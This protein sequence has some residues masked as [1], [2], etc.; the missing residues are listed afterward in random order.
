MGPEPT[1]S[2]AEQNLGIITDTFSGHLREFTE[3]F[4]RRLILTHIQNKT[5]QTT[6]KLQKMATVMTKGHRTLS[7]CKDQ[8]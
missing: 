6:E 5:N 4:V 7:T 1:I 2:T 8:K 3:S